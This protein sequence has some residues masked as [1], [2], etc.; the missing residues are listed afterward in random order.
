MKFL[1]TALNFIYVTN[2]SNIGVK[3]EIVH[4]G[5]KSHNECTVITMIGARSQKDLWDS[6]VGGCVISYDCYNSLCPKYK[7]ELFPSSVRIR[8]ANGTFI[9]NKGE[10]GIILKINN[11]RFTFPFL[12]LDQLSQQMIL[13]HNSSKAYH[14]GTLWNADDVMFLT[15][16]GIPFAEM[17]PTNDINALVFCMESTV[18]PPYSNGYIRCRM[19]QAKGNTYLGRSCVFEPSF[20]HR[21]LYSHCNTYEGLV[22]VDDNIVSSGVFNIILT[23]KSNRHIKIHS[24]QTMGMLHSCEDSQIC[25]L[26]EIVM[27]SQNLREGRDGKSDPDPTKGNPRTGRLNVNTLPKKDFS[28]VQINEVGPQHDYVHYRNQVCWMHQSINRPDMTWKDYKRRTMM[29]LLKM[30]GR[31]EPLLSYKCPLTPMTTCP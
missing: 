13:G 31:L 20:K 4:I 21:S 30:R 23:N 18:I 17:L 14:I 22:T 24:N 29:P 15:R 25:T 1:G 12:C 6:G 27:F 10:C 2:I 16:N 19:P 26:H 11:E 28:P 3:T 9:A 8:A 5:R 7:T